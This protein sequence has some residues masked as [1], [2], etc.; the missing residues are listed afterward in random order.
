MTK[1][2]KALLFKTRRKIFGF[3]LGN[4]SSIFQGSGIDFRE[5]KEYTVGDDVRKINWNV[6]ARL[7][8]PFVNLYNEERELNVLL[9]FL[10]GG[11]IHF[12]TKR[13]KQE[14]IAEV[15]GLLGFST[16]QN[17]DN[18]SM[19]IYSNR[20]EYFLEP[21]KNRGVLEPMLEQILSMKALG[22]R[23]DMEALVRHI[24]TRIKRKSLI[25][26]VGDFYENADL[27][28]ITAR[29]EVYALIVRDRFEESPALLGRYELMDPG[30]LQHRSLNLGGAQL[31]QY[32][33]MLKA[34]DAA[35]YQHF[36]DHRIRHA[37]NYTDEEPAAKLFEFFRG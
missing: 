12:G 27:A 30:T 32:A 20:E 1:P 2:T 36:R 37:K 11:S 14:V 25:F 6:T 7:Q 3:N 15:L 21:T 17:N 9:V 22:K 33:G 13:M 8:R 5:I 23:L 35:L 18:L 34:H 24:A 16:L 28:P 29:N 26:L 19:L 31:A 4:N 10:L